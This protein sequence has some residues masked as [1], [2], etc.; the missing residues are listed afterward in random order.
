MCPFR[1]SE[2]LPVIHEVLVAQ[3]TVMT[4]LTGLHICHKGAHLAHFLLHFQHISNIALKG[5]EKLMSTHI[6]TIHLVFATGCC[7]EGTAFWDHSYSWNSNITSSAFETFFKRTFVEKP[8][9][10]QEEAN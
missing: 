10:V 7:Q 3:M 9:Q 8:H 2:I 5:Y 1:T 6:P 4:E